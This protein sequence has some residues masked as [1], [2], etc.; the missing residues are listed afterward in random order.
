M[1]TPYDVMAA[2]AEVLVAVAWLC[3]GGG[4]GG[5]DTDAAILLVASVVVLEMVLCVS[6]LLLGNGLYNGS[7]P[8]IMFDLLS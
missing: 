5:N 8:L 1:N 6:L 3:Y 7:D 2:A 4:N